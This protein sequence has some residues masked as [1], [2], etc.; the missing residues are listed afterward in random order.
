MSGLFEIDALA[1]RL[2]TYVE[3][4]DA[5]K[6]EAVRVLEQALIRGEFE[7]GEIARITGLPE[8]SARRVLKDVIDAG[9]LASDTPKGAVSLRFPADTLDVLF[10]RLF[11]ESRLRPSGYSGI[12]LSQRQSRL[13][14]NH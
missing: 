5:L 1:K 6:P 7:R 14:A 12:A 10:P 9:L 4:S 8:R 11:V 3:R 13:H 2:R